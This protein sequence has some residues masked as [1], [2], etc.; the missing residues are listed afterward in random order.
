MERFRRY[1]SIL[2]GVLVLSLVAAACGGDD[3]SE[4]AGSGSTDLSGSISVVGSST[5][6]PISNAV[7][8]A[9]NASNPDVGINVTGLGTGDG[10]A[11]FCVGDA[12]ISDASRPIDEEEEVPICEEN[13]VEYV[14]LEVA[15]DGITVMTN[16][17]NTVECLND[18]DLYALFGPESTGIDTWN[19]ADELA[20]QVGGS[21]GFPDQSLEIDRPGRRVGN[22]RRVHRVVGYRGHRDRA[23]G[24][25][26]RG[27]IPPDRLH[28]FGRRQRDHHSDGEFRRGARLRRL[29]LRPERR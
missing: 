2:T 24:A 11:A 12:D 22:V 6:L 28:A 10:F 15:F 14:E 7:A 18:G 19:G 16:P 3:P 23:R 13:G 26:G 8:A 1:T 5:V 25:R 17:E 29:R 20:T 27:G 4:P 9:F 21:G